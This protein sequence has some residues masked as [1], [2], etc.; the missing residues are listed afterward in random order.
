MPI[1]PK[2]RATKRVKKSPELRARA[3]QA[4]ARREYSRAE[5]RAR[6]LGD[7]DKTLE[8]DAL[9]DDFTARGWLS[10]ERAAAQ[11]LRAKAARFG[12]PR[13]A[14]ELRLKG[15]NEELIGEA[16]GELTLSEAERA[17]RVWQKKYGKLPL[18]ARDKARQ[19]RFMHSRGFSLEVVLQVM[20]M[21]ETKN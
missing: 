12:A 14:H 19:M 13:I 8:L 20:R 6:L 5:L 11:L 2:S 4:L 3:L 17:A 16:L 10:D 21:N 15:I 9:L 7:G 18:D 1:P